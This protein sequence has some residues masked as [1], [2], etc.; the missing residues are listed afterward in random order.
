MRKAVL[1]LRVP[2]DE[3]LEAFGRRVEY[4]LEVPLP[5]AAGAVALSVRDDFAPNLS[6]VL[7]SLVPGSTGGS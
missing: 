5:E 2:N 3:L 6:T 4:T 1:P 7:L